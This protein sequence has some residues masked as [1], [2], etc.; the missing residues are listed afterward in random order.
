[1]ALVAPLKKLRAA[2]GGGKQFFKLAGQLTVTG[3]IDQENAPDLTI[4][5]RFHKT[6]WSFPV[7]SLTPDHP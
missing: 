3:G 4:F 7:P 1:M 5:D 6:I 2:P